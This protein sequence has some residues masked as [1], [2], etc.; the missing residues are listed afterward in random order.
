MKGFGCVPITCTAVMSHQV[1][2]IVIIN[3]IFAEKGFPSALNITILT[4]DEKIFPLKEEE[5]RAHR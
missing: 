4:L 3:H 5:S 2:S 1:L